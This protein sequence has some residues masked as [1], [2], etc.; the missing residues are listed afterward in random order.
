MHVRLTVIL[1]LAACA[2]DP[3]PAEVPRPEAPEAIAVPEGNQVAFVGH[4]TGVQIY[5]CAQDANAMLAWRLRAPRAEL[6]DGSKMFATH[7]GGVDV[8]SPAGPYWQSVEDGS[9]VRG[10][11]VVSA[12]N[13]GNIPLLRLDA[14]EVMGDGI[15]GR[16]TFIHRLATEGGVG[17]T[18]ACPGPEARM[19]VPYSSDYY[20]YEA[21]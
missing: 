11:N 2:T 6:F 18:G 21:M 5:E 4:A 8:G 17:P 13:P 12:P 20:F 14:V 9:S 1:M 19:E 3:L 15:F 7:F 16:V 10:G